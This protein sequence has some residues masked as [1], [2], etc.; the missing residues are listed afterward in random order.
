[1]FLFRA[2]LSV[3]LC[4]VLVAAGLGA[5]SDKLKQAAKSESE[6]RADAQAAITAAQEDT[7]AAALAAVAAKET[8][9]IK[10]QRRRW[11]ALVVGLTLFVLAMFVGLA[12]IAKIPP[13]LHAPLVSGSTTIGGITLVGAVIIAGASVDSFRE[14]FGSFLGMLA[15]ALATT[16]AIG[17]FLITHR[18]LAVFRR[19]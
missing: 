18:M 3:A 7:E 1:M 8:E 6:L 2:T 14:G 19:S 17:G 16:L 11:N 13:K 4:V 12:V 5:Y 15:V 10:A 9:F